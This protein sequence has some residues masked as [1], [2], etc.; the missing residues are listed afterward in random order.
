MSITTIASSTPTIEK[1]FLISSTPSNI[2]KGN[3]ARSSS[4]VKEVWDFY[5]SFNMLTDQDDDCTQCLPITKRKTGIEHPLIDTRTLKKK[6][7]DNHQLNGHTNLLRLTERKRNV[8]TETSDHLACSGTS[9]SSKNAS[10]KN[11]RSR[12]NELVEFSQKHG[13]CNV[14]YTYPSNEQLGDW[15]Q[16]QR[17]Q[18]KKICDGN[19]VLLSSERIEALSNLGFR[20]NLKHALWHQRYAELVQFREKHGHTNV[21]CLY[22]SN[23]KLGSWVG[24][25]R[26]E[27]KR[28]LAGKS[29]HLNKG[30]IEDLT[31][32]G[33]DWAVVGYW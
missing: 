29:S 21:P 20:F 2:Y 9:H 30:R 8:L 11:W 26:K 4:E 28:K 7:H 19:V 10:D 12:F 17:S 14:P 13:H 3:D 33:F 25:Q 18:F 16:N 5:D 15:V 24:T 32:I 22:H 1:H 6:K 23:P 27:F 31:K